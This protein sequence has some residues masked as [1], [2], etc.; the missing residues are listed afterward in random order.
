[1]SFQ[2]VQDNNRTTADTDSSILRLNDVAQRW[3]AMRRIKPTSATRYTQ[4]IQAL[5]RII[6]NVPVTELRPEH[7]E[8]WIVGRGNRLAPAGYAA[9]RA[10]ILSILRYTGGFGAPAVQWK[11]F[12]P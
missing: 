3:L 7:A 12:L 9:E 10:I 6:G 8:A 5:L 4:Q 11:Q 2:L 1:M